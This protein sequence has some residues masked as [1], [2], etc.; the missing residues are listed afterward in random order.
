MEMR[1]SYMHREKNLPG[2]SENVSVCKPVREPQEKLTPLNTLNL[3]LHASELWQ[4]KCILLKTSGPWY[5]VM[6]ALAN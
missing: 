5:L 3:D 6:A 2:N 4:N 1:E